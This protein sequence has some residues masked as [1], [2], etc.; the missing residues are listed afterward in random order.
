[1]LQHAPLQA[2]RAF[3]QAATL[4][5]QSAEVGGMVRVA[6]HAGDAGLAVRVARAVDQ[7][8]AADAA[9][10]AGRARAGPWRLRRAGAVHQAATPA[11]AASGTATDACASDSHTSPSRRSTG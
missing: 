8:A 4:A 9:V 10:A 6:F 3:G 2:A 1:G 11:V 7:H 5:A